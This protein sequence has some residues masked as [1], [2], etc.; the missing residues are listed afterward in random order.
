VNGGFEELE[1]EGS[2]PSSWHYQRQLTLQSDG[3]PAGSNYAV[4][5]NESAG[6][7]SQALQAM[8][9]DGRQINEIEV[10]V[11]ARAKNIGHGPKR[12]MAALGIL[13]Y[14]EQRRTVGEGVLGP[15]YGSFPWKKTSTR[16]HVPRQAREAILRIGLLGATGE[17][18]LDEVQLTVTKRSKVEAKQQ[19]PE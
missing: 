15:W 2:K 12:E 8:A 6:R 5:S 1:P 7:G 18:A 13:F 10:S 4:F 11:M 17:L 16:I 3:A 14:D 9:I 19:L